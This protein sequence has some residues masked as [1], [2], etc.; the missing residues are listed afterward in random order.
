MEIACINSTIQK[1]AFI[2][3]MLQALIWKLRAA[4]VQP[5]GRNSIQERISYE[6]GKLVAQLYVRT[7]YV[8]RLDDA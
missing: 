3:R 8:Y 4:K 7:P 5:S 2:V 1:T 6:F